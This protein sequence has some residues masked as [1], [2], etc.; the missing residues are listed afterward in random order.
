MKVQNETENSKAFM[1]QCFPNCLK[2]CSV[3]GVPTLPAFSE[4][5]EAIKKIN[6]YLTVYM[7]KVLGN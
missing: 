2:L 5:D 4:R 3:S 6:R 7:I 1:P